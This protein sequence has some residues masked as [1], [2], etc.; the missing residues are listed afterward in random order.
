M[1]KPACGG[2]IEAPASMFSGWWLAGFAELS[3][4][5]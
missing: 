2:K 5:R 4:Q 3:Q 1:M